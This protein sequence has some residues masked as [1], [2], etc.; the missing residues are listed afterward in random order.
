MKSAVAIVVDGVLRK[1]DHQPIPEGVRLYRMLVEQTNLVLLATGYDEDYRQGVFHFLHSE[2]LSGHSKLVLPNPIAKDHVDA[3]CIQAV[4]LRN[5]GMALDYIVE[6][7]LNCAAWLLDLGFNVMQFHHAKYIRPD[8][9]PG[10]TPAITPWAEM[11]AEQ[12]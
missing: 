11:I 3:R 9:K 4:H 1:A 12:A 10:T 8:W 6:P 2:G 5:S 7:D